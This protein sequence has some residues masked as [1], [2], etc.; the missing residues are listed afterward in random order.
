MSPP[1]PRVGIDL[2]S[3]SLGERSAGTARVGRELGAALLALPV[4]WEW[5]PVVEGPANPLFD[6]IQ[7]LPFQIAPGRRFWTRATWGMGTAWRQAGCRLGL[8][9]TSFTPPWGVPVVANF[10]DTNIY[11]HGDTWIQS[12]R[13]WNY[14]LIR[15]LSHLTLRRA[16]RLFVLSQYGVTFLNEVVPGVAARCV[17]VPC[18]LTALPEPGATPA[19]VT[20]GQR[21]FFL[22]SGSFSE[23]K[24]QRLL[25]EVWA[26]LQ[27]RHPDLPG[28]VLTGGCSPDYRTHRIEPA[29]ARLPRPAEVCLPGYVTDT[30]LAWAY[31]HCTG[32]VQPSLAEG[33]GLPLIEAMSHGAPVLSSRSTSLPET[34]GDAALYFEPNDAASLAEGIE[35]LW[36]DTA[37]RETLVARGR[38]RCRLFSWENSARLIIREIEAVLATI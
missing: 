28:L 25:I 33:F 4:P 19:W 35:R 38:E 23:N 13:R 5:V 15:A 14:Y 22:F 24:N 2:T 6:R 10:F 1:V 12:G 37:L 29:L 3:A 8:S 20:W 31:R 16:R 30:D 18:G 7:H 21:P 26:G 9:L 32:Y 36:H 27:Q 17:V 34:G 11:E